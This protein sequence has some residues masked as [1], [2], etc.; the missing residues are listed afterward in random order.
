MKRSEQRLL[1][2]TFCNQMRDAMLARSDKWP[3]EWDGHEL[4]ELAAYAFQQ[5]RT[6][7]MQEPRSRRARDASNAIICNNLY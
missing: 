5:E 7:L 4:R 1:L 3:T 2:R 6:R